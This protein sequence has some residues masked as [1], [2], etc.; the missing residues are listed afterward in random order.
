MILYI[1][2]HMG[3]YSDVYSSGLIVSFSISASINTLT[4]LKRSIVALELCMLTWNVTQIF[5]HVTEK[6]THGYKG[7]TP[8]KL[9]FLKLRARLLT[10]K[11]NGWKIQGQAVSFW[12][13]IAE[14][15]T[16]DGWNLVGIISFEGSHGG[17]NSSI[18]TSLC[19]GCIHWL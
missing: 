15:S 6:H 11:I 14:T 19:Y 17:S 18:G 5:F 2:K 13:K 12:R 9:P 1:W 7:C 10:L 16:N 8:S 3:Y 4:F